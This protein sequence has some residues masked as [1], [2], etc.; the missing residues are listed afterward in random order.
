MLTRRSFVRAISAIL[1]A[2]LVARFA[3]AAPKP[4][5][6]VGSVGIAFTADLSKVREAIEACKREAEYPRGVLGETYFRWDLEPHLPDDKELLL[7]G[8]PIKR[9]CSE[10]DIVQGWAECFPV[11]GG[12]VIGGTPYTLAVDADGVAR[13]HRLYGKLELVSRSEKRAH[14][15]RTVCDSPVDQQ[16]DSPAAILKNIEAVIQKLGKSLDGLTSI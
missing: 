7:N 16:F 12:S 15:D 3:G 6:S 2:S 4:A 10:V 8:V 13:T 11:V 9:A 1:P 14:S 5:T